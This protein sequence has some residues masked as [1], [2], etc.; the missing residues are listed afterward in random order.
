MTNDFRL[1]AERGVS[2]WM[3]KDLSPDFLSDFGRDPD[4]FLRGG[5]SKVLKSVARSTVVRREALLPSGSGA[6]VIKYF[7]PESVWRRIASSALPSPAVRAL[8]AALL[9]EAL[10]VKTARPL[11]AVRAEKN[12]G[13][14]Y[15]ISEEITDS[16][17]MRSLLIEIQRELPPKEAR[18]ARRRLLTGAAELFY[19]LHAARIYHRDLKAGNILVR[20]WQTPEWKMILVD[21]DG[22]TRM[23]RLWPS[24]RIKNLAQLCRIRRWTPRDRIYFLKQY[25]D[26]FG[27]TKADRRQLVRRVLESCRERLEGPSRR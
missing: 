4:A 10:G 13:A 7:H 17:S 3:R 9:L 26:R 2:G 12:R 27:M 5:G 15:Y 1:V 20:G 16:R 6:I 24:R 18:S 23:R 11:V 14:S 22:L 8:R 25:C 21:L 19:C